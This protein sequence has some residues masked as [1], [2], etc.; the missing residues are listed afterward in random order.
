LEKSKQSNRSS[1]GGVF[2]G[3]YGFRGKLNPVIDRRYVLDHVADAIRY[4]ET[5][6]A[7]GKVV[8]TVEW[9]AESPAELQVPALATQSLST[10][11]T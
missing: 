3:T 1:S 5:F 9:C 10:R 2:S 4:Q 7:R 6:H 8:L 11:V